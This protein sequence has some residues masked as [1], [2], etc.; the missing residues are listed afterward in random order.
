VPGG[1]ENHCEKLYARTA[2][3]GC[4]VFLYGRAPYIQAT[5]YE[6]ERISVIPLKSIRSKSF[7]TIIYT[8]RALLAASRIRPDIVHFHGIG[9]AF[10][11]PLVKLFKIPVVATHHGFDYERQKWGAFAKWFLKMGEKNSTRADALIA[12]SPHIDENIY[13]R[14][15]R[16]CTVIPNGVDLPQIK[17]A[18]EYCGKWSLQE[19]AYFLFVGR[20]VP[21]KCVH[22]LLD[23]FEKL[24]SN[25]KLVIAGDSD[26]KGIY[27]IDLKKKA[28]RNPSIVMTG[29]IKGEELR[30]LFSNAGCFIL[31]S[32]VEGMPIALLEALSYGLRCIVS[33]IPAHRAIACDAIDLFPLHSIS[34]LAARMEK[35]QSQG[36]LEGAAK[37]RIRDF[38]RC[39]FHWGKAAYETTRVYESVV[40]TARD[41][42]AA[43]NSP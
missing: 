1:I 13:R 21:E 6:Y 25:W 18:G 38:V 34:A 31:P 4:E 27:S 26:H 37:S 32:A 29:Y 35:H 14:T 42:K 33:D 11:V 12:V 5:P 20:I 28:H 30:E 8:V 22:E 39:N 19:K 17:S 9:P 23:A 15:G 16:R 43:E 36:A 24:K 40:A 3:R 10:F 7:E 2:L 41:R